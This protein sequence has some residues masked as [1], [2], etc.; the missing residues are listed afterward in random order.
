MGK[1]DVFD[2]IYDNDLS[3]FYAGQKLTGHLYI[4]T[5][6]PIRPET[7]SLKIKGKARTRWSKHHGKEQHDRHR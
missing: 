2:I 1:V 7:V 3:V 5:G 4:E 6:Q